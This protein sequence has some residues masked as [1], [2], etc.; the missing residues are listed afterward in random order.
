MVRYEVTRDDIEASINYLEVIYSF[1]M[2]RHS[3]HKIQEPILVGG[4]AVHSYNPW[5]GSLDIDLITNSK[6]KTSLEHFLKKQHDFETY[7]ILPGEKTVAKT[8]P[9]GKKIIIDF[10]TKEMGFEGHPNDILKS[11][12]YLRNRQRIE[13]TGR[14]EV[15]V[16]EIT[17]LLIYKLKAAWDRN[18]RVENESSKDMEWEE[19]KLSKDYCDVAALVDG[20]KPL[21]P[22]VIGKAFSDFPFLKKVIDLMVRQPDLYGSYTRI[23]GKREQEIGRKFSSMN[24][25]L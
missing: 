7:E 19:G 21:D 13:L 22:G 24:T 4:W 23:H 25:Y 18:Y 17:A 10:V 9:N 8:L 12:I 15:V 6:T 5:F 20:P 3:D 11:S 2:K 16:P 14:I 1:T